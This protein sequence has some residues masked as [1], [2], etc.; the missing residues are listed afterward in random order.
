MAIVFVNRYF[1]PDYSATSQL[2][3]DLSFDLARRGAEV[4]V[5][6]GRQI[7]DDPMASLPA[8]ETIRGVQVRRVWS[9]RFG[10]H[11]L[12]GRSLDYLGF[13]LS[14][15]CCAY[16]VLNRGDTL[17]A[18]TDPP[19][20]SVVMAR[21]AGLR[22][23]H[24]VNWLQDLFPEVA[25]ALGVR[26]IEGP[27]AGFLK[28][29]RNRSLVQARMNVALGALMARRLRAEGI[30]PQRICVIH[31]WADGEQIR[32]LAPVKNRL[33]REWGL[34][35]QFVVEYSGNMG[36]AHEFDTILDA[37]RI[38]STHP[39]FTFLFIGGG[40]LRPVIATGASRRQLRN[41]LFKPYQDR[42]R[43]TQSL[44]VGD[45]HLVSLQPRME[46]LIVP[47]KFY[48]IAAAGRACLYLGD[49]EGEI[50]QIIQASG[51]GICI[52]PGDSQALAR[53]LLALAADPELCR[54]QGQRARDVFEDRFDR[55]HGISA[56]AE[57]L[58]L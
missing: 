39:N 15:A 1:Y 18:K 33:R 17:V 38:L 14:S 8:W 4:T 47:S 19:M 40:V 28:W 52:A 21:V 43:L 26:G 46:G 29:I 48:G 6:T 7:I 20:L 58:G 56:W 34:E 3:T 13:Y 53:S 11:S 22:G 5:I 55:H 44:G 16:R 41:I 45:V 23:A 37:A 54:K 27:L 30:P 35:Q 24:L 9:P 12:F 10:R 2:L 51:C 50:G 42:R 31:N 57:V 32:P 25:V 49:A 36:R